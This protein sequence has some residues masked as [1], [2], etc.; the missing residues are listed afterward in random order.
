LLLLLN[1]ENEPLLLV[2]VP[3]IVCIIQL[4]DDMFLDFVVIFPVVVETGPT[5][6]FPVVETEPTDMFPLVVD[7]L[8]VEDY[9]SP[10]TFIVPD[11]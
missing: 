8:P 11:S 7:M 3:L 2:I 1:S 9:M 4:V 5:D 6:T 10:I